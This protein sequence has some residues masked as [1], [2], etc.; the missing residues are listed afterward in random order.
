[1]SHDIETANFPPA[2]ARTKGPFPLTAVEESVAQAWAIYGTASEVAK[3]LGINRTTVANILYKPTVHARVREIFESRF[4]E[5]NI[6]GQRV[7][8]ELARVAFSDIRECFDLE[9]NLLPIHLLSADAAACISSVDTE[10]VLRGRGDDAEPVLIKKIR[11]VD[12]TPALNLL[13]RHF[14]IV[15]NDDDG[16]NNL[17]NALADKLKAARKRANG[18]VVADA[19]EVVADEIA[20]AA[21]EDPAGTMPEPARLPVTQGADDEDLWG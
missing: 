10:V 14:K 5:Q 9:G 6:T 4:S 2:P 17:A 18:Q 1:M 11:R 19:V 15:G 21:A 8:Q 16:V 20:A 13:A 3:Q 12:K 7:M